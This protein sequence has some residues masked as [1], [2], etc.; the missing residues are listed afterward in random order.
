MTPNPHPY[1]KLTLASQWRKRQHSVSLTKTLCCA[2]GFSAGPPGL[3]PPVPVV[4]VA[5]AFQKLLLAASGVLYEDTYLQARPRPVPTG[6]ALRHHSPHSDNDFDPWGFSLS[7]M[8][9][10][11]VLLEPLHICWVMTSHCLA[12]L[13]RLR[14]GVH[15]QS[16]LRWASGELS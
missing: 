1:P 8:M 3:P 15:E 4:D 14:I 13:T 9:P 6:L 10:R 12:L 2:G 16:G 5:A 11:P 7:T